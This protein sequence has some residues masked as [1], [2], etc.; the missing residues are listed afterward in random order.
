MILAIQGEGSRDHG[1]LK[2][3]P[4]INAKKGENQVKAVQVCLNR[5]H[6]QCQMHFHIF[7]TTPVQCRLESFH[8]AFHSPQ[9]C[10]SY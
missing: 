2:A 1:M 5:T 9:T 4:V 6:T 7:V 10:P 3:K 8:F